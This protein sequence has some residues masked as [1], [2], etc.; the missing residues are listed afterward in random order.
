MAVWTF[1]DYIELTGRNP[2]MRWLE[3]VPPAAAAKIDYRLLHMAG[4]SQWPEKWLS[5]YQGTAEIYELRITDNKVQYRPLGSYF[6][7]RQFILLN[8]AIEKGGKIPKSD[9]ETA[10]RRLKAAQGDKRHVQ[11]HQFDDP[12]DLEADGEKGVS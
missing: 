2:I 7:A 9:I 12:G 3:S 6:G 8:G 4:T 1:Y 11:F 5:K 10:E